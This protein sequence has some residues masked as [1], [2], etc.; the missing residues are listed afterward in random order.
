M[1]V[2]E[3]IKLRSLVAD[4]FNINII[5]SIERFI[6]VTGISMMDE[7]SLQVTED[8]KKPQRYNMSRALGL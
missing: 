2:I 4:L 8:V 1:V 3:N 5:S 6:V 7:G